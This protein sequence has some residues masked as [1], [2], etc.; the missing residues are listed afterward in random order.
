MRIIDWSSDVCSS[1]LSIPA[2]RLRGLIDAEG[3]AFTQMAA[4][5]GDPKRGEKGLA[6]LPGRGRDFRD[7]LSRALD[8]AEA[9]GCP[10]IHTME[11]VPEGDATEAT[12]ETYREKLAFA[13]SEEHRLNSSH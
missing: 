12:A 3:L 10:L 4:G 13:R 11:G 6:A 1:D 9:L 8:Y 5:T 2:P 7:G